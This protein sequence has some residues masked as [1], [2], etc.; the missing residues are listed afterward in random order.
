MEQRNLGSSGLIVSTVGLG[1]NNFGGRSDF[2]ATRAV[3]HKALDL[4]VT[5]FDTSDTYGEGGASEEYLGRALAGRRH[6]IIVA[7]NVLAHLAA[8]ARRGIS[9]DALIRGVLASQAGLDRLSG[10]LHR[11]VMRVRLVPL[12]MLFRSFP[13]LVREIGAQLGEAWAIAAEI[14]AGDAAS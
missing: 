4:G 7:S 10:Q 5:L 12:A 13:R 9:G 3:V 2:A 14:R 1:C 8:Q 6:E 11:A